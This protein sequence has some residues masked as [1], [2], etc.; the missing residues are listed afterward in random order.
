VGVFSFLFGGLVVFRAIIAA[1]FTRVRKLHPG[2]LVFEVTRCPQSDAVI[3]GLSASRG[4]PA[5]WSVVAVDETGL[6]WYLGAPQLSG[7]VRFAA[8]DV[9]DLK[10]TSA[11]VRDGYGDRRVPAIQVHMRGEEAWSFPMVARSERWSAPF[12]TAASSRDTEELLRNVR[13]RL[14]LDSDI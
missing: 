4:R 9:V 12:R 13:S 7:S 8:G 5:H 14:R 10:L 11:T 3:R 2:A 6:Q 1:R